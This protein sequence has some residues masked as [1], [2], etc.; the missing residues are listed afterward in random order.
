M[1]EVSISTLFILTLITLV[2]GISFSEENDKSSSTER[3]FRPRLE[4]SV[5]SRI[6]HKPDESDGY[7]SSIILDFSNKISKHSE[8]SIRTIPLFTYIQGSELD[9]VYG[10][11]IGCAYRAFLKESFVKTPYIEFHEVFCI[12][13]NYFEDNNSNVNFNTAISIGY[14]FNH[15]LDISLR[16]SHISNAN[17][18]ENNDSTNILSFSTGY[19]F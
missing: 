1:K 13:E 2:H 7:L 5:G 4:V 15:N 19:R 16:L 6:G 12:H 14:Q 11:G 17:L 9:N 3:K 8:I 10:I 18:K